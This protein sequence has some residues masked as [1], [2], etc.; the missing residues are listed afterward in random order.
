MHI[1]YSILNQ[2]LTYKIFDSTR[3]VEYRYKIEII[4]I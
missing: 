4:Y 2:Y 3:I 1:E